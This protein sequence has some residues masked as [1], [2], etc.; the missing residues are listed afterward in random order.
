V[1]EKYNKNLSIF[2]VLVPDTLQI[3]LFIVRVQLPSTRYNSLFASLLSIVN[4]PGIVFE[5]LPILNID[6]TPEKVTL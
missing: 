3:M 2:N 6:E 5:P 1:P 4:V